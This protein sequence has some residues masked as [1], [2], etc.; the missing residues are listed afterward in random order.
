MENKGQAFYL[1]IPQPALADLRSTL[2]QETYSPPA[3]RPAF[4][5]H[6]VK[7]FETSSKTMLEVAS[8]L[9]CFLVIV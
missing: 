3:S 9:D 8:W 7:D 5:K 6:A 4:S 1:Q 2:A